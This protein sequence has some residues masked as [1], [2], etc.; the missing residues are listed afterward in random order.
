MKKKEYMD[1][2]KE[3]RYGER[4]LIIIFI[5]IVIGTIVLNW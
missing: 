2:E 3:Y 5:F 1:M 4:M